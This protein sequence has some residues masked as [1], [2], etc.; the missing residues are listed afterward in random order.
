MKNM[1][2]KFLL[3][4][5][6]LLL[7]A[8]V[9]SVGV[10]SLSPTSGMDVYHAWPPSLRWW[11]SLALDPQWIVAIGTSGLVAGIS[12]LAALCL[13]L[14]VVLYWRVTR[15]SLAGCSLLLARL[16]FCLPPV[17]LAVGLYQLA[18]R[19]GLFDTIIGLSLTH[20]A[21][22]L[23]ITIYILMG[24]FNAEPLSLYHVARGLGSKPVRA[25]TTWL[26]ATQR[27]TLLACIGASM[28][29][30]MSEVTVTLYVTDTKVLTISRKIL[31]G[32]TRDINPTGFA[33]MSAWIIAIM[34]ILLFT[35]RGPK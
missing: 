15:S 20:L 22:T 23:P 1:G 11:R 29:I 34:A 7:L 9:A 28:L 33:A 10:L 25:A 35:K 14:P 30:S 13:G 21:F 27:R 31:S 6:A 3:C 16:S 26:N 24:R 17:V 18:T 32:I 4:V 5:G 12:S 8:P 19:S 2:S